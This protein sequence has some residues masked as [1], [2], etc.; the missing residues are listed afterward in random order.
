MKVEHLALNIL[1]DDKMSAENIIK[2]IAS[3]IDE[4]I[5]CTQEYKELYE[6]AY[7]EK[8][9]NDILIEFVKSMSVTDGSDR[10]NGQKWSVDQAYDIG[11]KLGVDWN[12]HSKYE[13][14]CVLNM[15]YSDY[16]KTAKSVGMQDDPMF[17]GRLAKD[18]ICDNDTAENK[19]YNYYFS[20]IV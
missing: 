5:D 14:Y 6:C 13:W 7:G 16:Y 19:L 10:E 4:D 20:V 18:W 9:S 3:A 11:S 1:H 8:L 15:C 12:K 17:F 2:H